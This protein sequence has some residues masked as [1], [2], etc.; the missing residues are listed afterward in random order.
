MANT[1]ITIYNRFVAFDANLF[2]ACPKF[3]HVAMNMAG[4]AAL[5]QP[6]QTRF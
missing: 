2:P 5:L 3:N 1:T 4:F 6:F